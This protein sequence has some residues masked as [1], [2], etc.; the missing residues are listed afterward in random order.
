MN[1]FKLSLMILLGFLLFIQIGCSHYPVIQEPDVQQF[2]ETVYSIALRDSLKDGKLT[3]GM[4]YFVVTQLFKNWTDGIKEVKIPVAT[5]GSKQRL[6]EEEGWNRQYVDPNIKVFLDVY[7]T[8]K[9]KLYVWYQRPD[10][11]SMEV[12][13]RD[14][15]YVFFED[16]TYTSAINYLTKSTVLSVKDSLAELPVQ[17]DFYAEVRYNDHPWRIIS[18]W[19][20]L[21]ILSNGRTFKIG[22]TNYELYPVELLEFN[23]EPVTSFKWR[24][25]N[26]DEN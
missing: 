19:Y 3:A 2:N 25:V 26:E 6:V 13:A 12:S 7:E 18:Y 1:K 14:T 10:F 9:G 16:S 8:P 4:P 24:E 22:E 11:Y 20:N 5:L 21:E 15:L 17:T 23:N